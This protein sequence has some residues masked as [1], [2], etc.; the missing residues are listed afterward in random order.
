MT[1]NLPAEID[2]TDELDLI[3]GL[4][5]TSAYCPKGIPIESIIDL[6]LKGLSTAQIGKVL[7]CSHV[8]IVNRLKTVVQDIDSLKQYKSH[9]ADIYAITGKRLLKNLT[10]AEIKSMAP[11]SRITAM[12]IL[13]DKERLERGESTANIDIRAVALKTIE[14]CDRQLAE[15]EGDTQEDR[16]PCHD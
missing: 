8:N 11:A 12:A 10:D 2:T 13:A 16:P 7:G 14:D 4:P 9:R 15:L 3:T 1:D 6:R 5:D